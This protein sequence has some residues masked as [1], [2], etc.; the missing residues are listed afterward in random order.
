[1]WWLGGAGARRSARSGETQTRPARESQSTQNDTQGWEGQ[2]SERGPDLPRRAQ[3]GKRVLRRAQ[4][5]DQHQGEQDALE[6]GL[7]L[8]RQKW[9]RF[10]PDRKPQEKGIEAGEVEVVVITRHPSLCNHELHQSIGSQTFCSQDRFTL[11]EIIENHKKL[12]F[13]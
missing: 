9:Q 4:N 11:L 13:L 10:S 5:L 1:M 6:G 12:L 2:V 8:C 3:P 7:G